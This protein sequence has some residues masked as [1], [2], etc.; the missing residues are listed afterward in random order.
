[1]SL[2]RALERLERLGDSE[3]DRAQRH[4]RA[5]T[6]A[7]DPPGLSRP[8]GRRWR[9]VL[10]TVGAL[11]VCTAVL[12]WTLAVSSVLGVKRIDVQGAVSLPAATVSQ[13]AAIP[14]GTPLLRLDTA[15]VQRRVGALSDVASVQVHV[16]YPST[17]IVSIV[18]R[19]PVLVLAGPTRLVDRTGLAYR[20]AA[21]APPGIPTTSV[22]GG[23]LILAAE[24]SAALPAPTRALVK[25]VSV[26]PADGVSLKLTDGRTVLW[27]GSD[28]SGEKAQ[29]L[30][31][32]LLAAPGSSP[33]KV[34]GSVID[35][36]DP[37]VVVTR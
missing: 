30:S 2:L 11:I 33:P 17:V 16:S 5:A 12:A 3:A 36:R 9:T 1:M 18:E 25:T 22:T 6:R 37:S 24:V 26:D 29:L 8:R 32:L 27:G 13:A 34:P 7:P 21:T 10:I 4:G 28:R 20:Q 15:A 31:T 14:P 23:Q 35:L 19:V